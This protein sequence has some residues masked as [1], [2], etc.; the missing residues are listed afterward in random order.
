MYA[1]EALFLNKS[2]GSNY[3]QWVYPDDKDSYSGTEIPSLEQ[4]TSGSGTSK[5]TSSTPSYT[6]GNS[7]SEG[8]AGNPL[9]TNVVSKATPEVDKIASAISLATGL[10][11][12]YVL[13]YLTTRMNTGMKDLTKIISKNPILVQKITGQS[14]LPGNSIQKAVEKFVNKITPSSSS[15]TL[16]KVT[17][18]LKYKMTGQKEIVEKIPGKMGHY[19]TTTTTLRIS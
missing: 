6:A 2:T 5:S 13:Y 8:S 18:A 1:D 19:K 11:K 15:Q 10:G 3:K 4:V 14:Y 9:K 17:P 7:Y 16:E 12:G